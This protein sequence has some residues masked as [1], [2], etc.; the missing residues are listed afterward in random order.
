[1][2]RYRIREIAQQSGLSPATVDRVLNERPGVRATTV[3]E[4]H[5]AIADL[6]R[7]HEQVRLVGR[8]FL[9]DLVMQA[10]ARFSTAVRLALEAE[11]PDL[12][13]AVIRARFRLREEGTPTDLA[14][15]LDKIGRQGSHG[16]LLKAPDD[17][18]I[19]RAVDRLAAQGVPV[20]TLVTDV[21]LSRRIGYVGIDNRAAGATAAYL[22]TRVQPSAGAIL[23]TLS[24]SS[25]RG[26]EEREI[27]FRAAL[28]TMAPLRR[29]VELS[30]TDG[31]DASMLA[32]VTALLRDEPSLDSVYSI[33]G[34]NRAILD[35]FSQ[36]GRT[37]A[38][39]VAHDLD[40]DNT[41]LL[42]RGRLTAVLHHDL[43]TDLRQACRLIMQAHGALPGH[44]SSTPSQVQV[45]TPYNEPS[46]HLS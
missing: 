37:P 40:G 33:G 26:E 10:P 46:A 38:A 1:M 2:H 39:F 45:V 31:L 9:V 14:A 35:A 18:E 30:E 21:P 11:L 25:F 3:A 8:T 28:R 23:V 20:V 4:V 19:A 7:Q 36:A 16:V 32:G 29:V 24:S 41:G 43:R 15:V 17:S 5:R 12:R 34:G 42:R 22:L 6:E 27:G 44:P 13:P